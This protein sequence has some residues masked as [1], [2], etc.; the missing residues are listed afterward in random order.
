[1]A[2][3]AFYKRFPPTLA[4]GEVCGVRGCGSCRVTEEEW[5]RGKLGK[6]RSV[7]RLASAGPPLRTAR[8]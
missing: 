3:L 1:M 6:C 4:I 2:N 5:A 7:A 8:W